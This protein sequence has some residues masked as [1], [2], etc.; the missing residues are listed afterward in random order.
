MGRNLLPWFALVLFQE[1][2]EQFPP[3]GRVF[4]KI[5]HSERAGSQVA[6]N[7]PGNKHQPIFAA[8][9]AYFG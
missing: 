1:N 5:A 8:G 6:K 7:I 2:D 3:Y 4:G 9:V